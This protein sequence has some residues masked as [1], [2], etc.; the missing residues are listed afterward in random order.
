M[1]DSTSDVEPIQTSDHTV[2]YDDVTKVYGEGEEKVVAVKDLELDV[3][4]G[5][6]ISIV[7]P[8]GCGKTTLLHLTA[9]LLPATQGSIEIEG[10]NVQSPE[11]EKHSVGL[12]FQ[13]PVL[14][15]WRT[16]RKNVLLPIEI[17]LENDTIDGDIEQYREKANELLELVGL[18]G[19]EESYPKELSGG[20]QQRVSICRSLIY[21]P[22]I[23]LMDEPFGALDAFTRDKMNEELLEIWQET[24]KT[25]VFVTHNLEEATFLSDRVVILSPRPGEIVDVFDIDLARPRNEETRTLDAFRDHVNELYSHFTDLEEL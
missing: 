3:E 20:M 9:G 18:E 12:V 14:L 11:H 17:M 10:T 19:F 22:K 21:D 2:T 1:S 15:D 25:I 24:N 16:V 5:E 4:E 23:L 6:F 13:T 7:G 8:S